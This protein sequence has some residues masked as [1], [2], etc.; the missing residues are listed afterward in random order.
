ML[1]IERVQG[2]FNTLLEWVDN[3]EKVP[4]LDQ[5]W[6]SA[7]EELLESFNNKLPAELENYFLFSLVTAN[8]GLI[9]IKG[10]K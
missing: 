1:D 8:A 6:L 7:N 4:Y 3:P 2:L 10:V 5:D 9:E